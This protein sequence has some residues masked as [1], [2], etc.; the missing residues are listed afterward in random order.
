MGSGRPKNQRHREQLATHRAVIRRLLDG[1]EPTLGL[2]YWHD[3]SAMRDGEPMS[4]HEAH[5][6]RRARQTTEVDEP[7]P[8]VK[9]EGLDGEV[10]YVP[11]VLDESRP[12]WWLDGA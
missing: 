9:C 8:M 1:W 6:I 10:D 3:P 4:E 11:T 5:T 2:T 12:T 7:A